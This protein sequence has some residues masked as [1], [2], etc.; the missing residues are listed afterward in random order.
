MNK[1]NGL[2]AKI[3]TSIGA[4]I[5]LSMI[6]FIFT[7]VSGDPASLLIPSDATYE[8]LLEMR[9]LLGL[10]RSLPAQF[11]TFAS[12]AL[13]GDFGLSLRYGQPAM[14]LVL[15]RVPATLELAFF[16]ALIGWAVAVPL[17]ILSGC[18]PNSVWDAVARFIALFGQSMPVYWLGILLVML[19]SIK[20][21]LLP[22]SGRGGFGHL[23]LPGLALSLNLMGSVTRV[24]RASMVEILRQDYIRAARARGIS[25]KALLFKHALKNG[26]VGMV[27]VIGLQLGSL[28]GGTVVTETVFAWPGLGRFIVQSIQFRD[29]PVVQAGVLFLAVVIALINTTTDLIYPLL[30][31]RVRV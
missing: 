15:A 6:T 18:K 30:D 14:E 11:L 4:V 26:A 19:F 27:T 12:G 21:R 9:A 5:L 8:E 7:R 16:A 17:G 22:A 3:A 10:D 28:V 29:F 1:V 31:S 23:I 25:Q 2:A 20:L 24:L 13:K